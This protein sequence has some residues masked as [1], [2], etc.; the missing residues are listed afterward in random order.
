MP[1]L[2]DLSV[3]ARD[4]VEALLIEKHSLMVAQHQGLAT[5]DS[6]I[7]HLKAIIAKL[8]RMMFGAKSVTR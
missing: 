6:E 4:A 5:R 3:L 1:R 7:E 8:R 2:P